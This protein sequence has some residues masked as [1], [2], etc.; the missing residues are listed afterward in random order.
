MV[1]IETEWNL[2]N[3]CS[4][5]VRQARRVD[6]ETEWNLKPHTTPRRHYAPFW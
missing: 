5:Q 4:G 2:K 6:I 1:D 3:M